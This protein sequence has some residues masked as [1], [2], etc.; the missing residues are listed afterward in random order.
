[1]ADND[2]KIKSGIKKADNKNTLKISGSN[3]V[4]YSLDEIVAENRHNSSKPLVVQVYKY[5]TG[6]SSNPP[7][8]AIGQ[9]WLSKKED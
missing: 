2:N 3:G 8:L 6:E 9:I 5:K 7:D 4:S 1:M